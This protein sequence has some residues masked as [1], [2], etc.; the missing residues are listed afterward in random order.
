[1]LEL[2]DIKKTYQSKR[3]EVEAL[4]GITLTLPERGMVFIVG[5]SGSGKSTL[6]NILGGLDVPTAGELLIDGKSTK[7]F[8]AGDYDRYRNEYVGFVF[9]EYNLIEGLNVIENVSMALDL[10]GE[11]DYGAVERELARVEL[12]G[13][14][15]RNVSTLSGGQKQRVA[16][17]RALVKQPKILIADEPTGALDSETGESLFRLLKDIARDRLIV[18]VSHDLE[19]ARQYADRI[20]ELKDGK[21]IADQ[22]SRAP[23][24]SVK[25]IKKDVRVK[26]R[27]LNLARVF[28]LA[29]KGMKKNPVR[30][31]ISLV[32]CAFSF[33][34]LGI[35]FLSSQYDV[36]ETMA[37][38]LEKYD[39]E[40]LLSRNSLYTYSEMQQLRGT[41]PG[42]EFNAVFGVDG[43]ETGR[44][45]VTKENE[46]DLYSAYASQ[47]RQGYLTEFST[48]IC[49]GYELVEGRLPEKNDEVA[50]PLG[51]FYAMTEYGGENLDWGI[52]KNFDD[53]LGK[54]FRAP[55][56][57]IVGIVDTKIDAKF[58]I[59]K[60]Y[61]YQEI[62]EIEREKD[63]TGLRSLF[64]LYCIYM[65]DSTRSCGFVKEGFLPEQLSFVNPGL[66]TR[67]GYGL[68]YQTVYDTRE[69]DY[70]AS[71]SDLADNDKI[72]LYLKGNKQDI[73]KDEIVLP[74]ALLDHI[75][76]GISSE[77]QG[78]LDSVVD[79]Y[80]EE[81]VG[82]LYEDPAFC[83]RFDT[84]HASTQDVKIQ[85]AAAI[86]NYDEYYYENPF[87]KSGYELSLPLREK[88]FDRTEISLQ[89]K[90]ISPTGETGYTKKVVGFFH[91]TPETVRL[92]SNRHD[93]YAVLADNDILSVYEAKKTANIYCL[94]VNVTSGN[95]GE[96]FVSKYKSRPNSE[97]DDPFITGFFRGEVTKDV[98]LVDEH[99]YYF[100]TMGLLFGGV[101]A[102]VSV[103]MM[104]NFISS[105][106]RDRKREIGILRALGTTAGGVCKIFA[107][108]ALILSTVTAI[109]A[110]I[111]S[112]ITI[113][114]LNSIFIAEVITP[115]EP[116]RFTGWF[117]LLLLGV[118]LL[119]SL[120]S[121]IVPLCRIICMQPVDA[122]RE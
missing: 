14:E 18:V 100:K 114:Q 85:Y 3:V 67:D 31:A 96:A 71:F 80:V 94:S 15:K 44:I 77:V 59:L 111:L 119:I 58:D 30:C 39:P 2:K 102:G 21:V 88:I 43:T 54:Y 50:I 65:E 109:L 9:Q 36:N 55:Y 101:L 26:R 11:K 122:I 104:F 37:Y 70:I 53:I 112:Y 86:C 35:S 62:M 83:Q 52:V 74:W 107:L 42:L 7:A 51:M 93:N 24:S 28:C 78:K 72:N 82:K 6:L 95:S 12:S 27:G 69:F 97:S 40:V 117:I 76:P 32:L 92:Y 38:S 34:L 63:S 99:F 121:S 105:N 113:I 23:M 60:D 84:E 45:V 116:L 17:A 5:K 49:N 22:E 106:V 46:P 98:Q 41:Y 73:G 79:D 57:Q 20:I 108:E 47:N 8:K 10:Q 120:V 87:G 91:D 68:A 66:S 33:I 19:F 64:D 13:F 1:M 29:L 115:I 61:T 75:R 16:I 81:T 90:N 103:L 118:S 56:L 89:L 4:K 25:A 48:I 110:S